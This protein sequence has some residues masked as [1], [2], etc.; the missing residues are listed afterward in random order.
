MASNAKITGLKQV[1][2]IREYETERSEMISI[3]SQIENLITEGVAPGKIAVIYKENKYGLE[4]LSYFK[5]KNLP[6]YNK[7]SVN[8]LEDPLIGQILLM[9]RY[10]ASAHEHEVP[11]NGDEMLFEILH[12][13]WFHIPAI[14]IATL[15]AELAQKPSSE[16]TSLRKLLNDKANKPPRDLFSQSI[17]PNLAAAGR[18]IESLVSAVSNMT[19]QALVEMVYRETGLLQF[20]MQDHQKRKILET[21]TAFFDFIKEETRRQPTLSLDELVT[22]LDLMEKEGIPLP[23]VEVNGSAEAVNLLTV[24]GSKGLEFTY[25][26]FAGCN[27][28]NWEKKKNRAAD[29]SFPIPFL[30]PPLMTTKNCAGYFM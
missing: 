10:L 18:I 22:H 13:E 5:L 15:T 28:H 6:V 1:P 26:F 3:V 8:L 11:F 9:I 17:H 12:A 25:V 7:R 29:F 23:M 20:A 27:S 16:K 4:L 14:D 24:H 21:L 30:L 19:L 2:E